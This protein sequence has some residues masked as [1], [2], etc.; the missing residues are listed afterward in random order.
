MSVYNT[1]C[2][3]KQCARL[4]SPRVVYISSL[5]CLVRFPKIS[6]NKFL[7]GISTA[8]NIVEGMQGMQTVQY[9]GWNIDNYCT[10]VYKACLYLAYNKYC[11]STPNISLSAFLSFPPLY[12]M[13]ITPAANLFTVV[14]RKR[15][16]QY[17]DEM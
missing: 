11:Y 17:K 16:K 7:A 3:K 9:Q 13:L 15:S 4:L 5:Y 2:T 6:V 14:L 8:Y 10:L 1:I 12:Y